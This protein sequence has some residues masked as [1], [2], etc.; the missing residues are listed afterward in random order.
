MLRTVR[1]SET[2]V[3]CASVG[4]DPVDASTIWI[5]NDRAIA[6]AN[7]VDAVIAD[8]VVGIRLTRAPM[9]AAVPAVTAKLVRRDR[10]VIDASATIFAEL[11][12]RRMI[13]IAPRIGV[14]AVLTGK[15]NGAVTRVYGRAVCVERTDAGGTVLARGT[16]ANVFRAAAVIAMPAVRAVAC[17]CDRWHQRAVVVIAARTTILARV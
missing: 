10:V 1:P 6:M 2:R 12:V 16:D 11:S 14:T 5:Q 7:T 15:A 9:E 3:A 13:S 4:V 17:K 8:A